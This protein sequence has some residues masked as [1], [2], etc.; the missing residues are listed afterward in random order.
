MVEM[1][2]AF[3]TDGE[4]GQWL[5]ER[6]VA[7]R[8]NGILYLHG[9]VSPQTAALGCAGLNQAVRRELAVA[10]PTPEQRAAMLAS[11]ETGPLW[12][13]GLADEAEAA[14]A[15]TLA[16]ILEQVG[17]RAIVIGH[18]VTDGF[19]IRAR[20]DGRVIQIDTGMLGGTFY[21]GGEPSALVIQ[22]G[23]ATAVYVSGRERLPAPAL[24]AAA[25]VR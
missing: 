23:T 2:R 13:R 16:A 18:T 1:Q 8:I 22:G 25:A 10:N 12:Y 9:G 20:F 7:A 17:A 19:R 11:A 21:P 3:S 15:P 6:P 5:R 4:Y 24:E 14:F